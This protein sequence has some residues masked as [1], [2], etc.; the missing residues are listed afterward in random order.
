VIPMRRGAALALLALTAWL[1][2][3]AGYIHAK[4]GVAQMLLSRAWTEAQATGSA[5]K[6]W[7]WADTAPLARLEVPRLDISEIVLRGDSGRSLAFGPAWNEGSA[8]PGGRGT[9]VIS[10]H[11][12]T[13]FSFLQ[14][15]R[16]DDR[17]AIDGVAGRRWYR[18]TQTRIVDAHATRIDASSRDDSLLL[19]TCYPFDAIAAGGPLRYVV[20]AEAVDAA[21]SDLASNSR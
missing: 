18:V 12:D 16:A 8:L 19:V 2:G 6:P 17:I 21:P 3:G 11:R 5:V 1:W 15:L 20:L 7:P 4:A 10:G 13:H 9:S 14:Q